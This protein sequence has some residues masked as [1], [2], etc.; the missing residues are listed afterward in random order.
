MGEKV[1]PEE[2]EA[3][4]SQPP[5]LD[6]AATNLEMPE[7]LPAEDE[8]EEG[9]PNSKT[10]LTRRKSKLAIAGS[11]LKRLKVMS[12]SSSSKKARTH[13]Q[14]PDPDIAAS[15]PEM[16]LQPNRT[17]DDIPSQQ[18]KKRAKRREAKAKMSMSAMSTERP[19]EPNES[20]QPREE[21]Q[22]PDKPADQDR[23]TTP[24]PPENEKEKQKEHQD[25]QEPKK[26]PGPD[27]KAKQE[28]KDC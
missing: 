11:K 12:P 2:P 1:E 8:F 23:K 14:D 5:P 16:P 22:Q 18:P 28:A 19:N 17:P 15:Q 27:E 25:D 10:K 24:E 3:K 21:I 13:H 7:A 4:A 6:D 20:G 9:Q 26:K